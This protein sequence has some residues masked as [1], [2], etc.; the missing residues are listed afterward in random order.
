MSFIALSDHFDQDLFSCC[1]LPSQHT[2][3]NSQTYREKP[4]DFH[5]NLDVLLSLALLLSNE[6]IVE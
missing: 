2:C 3:I 1:L 5:S 4:H 6:L